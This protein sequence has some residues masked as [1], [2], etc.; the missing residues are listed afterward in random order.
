[1]LKMVMVVVVSL[2]VTIVVHCKT[3]HEGVHRGGCTKGQFGSPGR[4]V[5]AP[6]TAPA[7]VFV[8]AEEEGGRTV[9]AVATGASTRDRARTGD[10]STLALENVSQNLISKWIGTTVSSPSSSPVQFHGRLWRSELGIVNAGP[11]VAR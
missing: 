6:L 10:L 5:V 4:L 7:A 1:M 3:R 8:I 2:D 9:D 11:E